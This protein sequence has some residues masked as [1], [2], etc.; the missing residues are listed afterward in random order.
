MQLHCT[1]SETDSPTMLTTI[2][3]SKVDMIL[4]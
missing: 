3:N 2:G 4:K 1:S